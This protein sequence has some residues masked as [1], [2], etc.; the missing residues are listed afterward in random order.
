MLFKPNQP[1]LLSGFTHLNDC[2]EGIACSNVFTEKFD[3]TQAKT[4]ANHKLH[5]NMLMLFCSPHRFYS[6][7]YSISTNRMIAQ[8]SITP[9]IA[10]SPVST[11]QVSAAILDRAGLSILTAWTV[12]SL[13]QRLGYTIA[14]L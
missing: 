8:T 10:A 13:M 11:Y 4:R 6:S 12:M 7:P 3:R 2:A 1:R 9:F 5:A 14:A